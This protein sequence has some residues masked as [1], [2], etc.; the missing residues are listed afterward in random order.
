MGDAPVALSLLT[1][2]NPRAAATVISR[3][4]TG[5][6]EN[7]HQAFERSVAT[8]VTARHYTKLYIRAAKLR[9]YTDQRQKYIAT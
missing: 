4:S 6:G 2:R 8:A 9:S 1:A 7:I 5:L 3:G